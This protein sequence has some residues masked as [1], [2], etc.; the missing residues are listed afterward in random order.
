MAN[1]TT[2]TTVDD[3][4]N[5]NLVQPIIVLALSEQPGY[6][7][8]S[9]RQIDIRNQPTNT[10]KIP[11]EH[12]WWGSANDRGAGVATAFNQT[13]ATAISNTALS[14]DG[15]TSASATEYGV[16]TSLTDNVGE[17]SVQGIDLVQLFTTRMLS[18]LTL[19]LDDDYIGLFASL[20][21]T[22]GVSGSAATI[23]QIV[24]A[25]QGIRTRGAIADQVAYVLGN[26]TAGYIETALQSGTAAQF[27]LA[28]DRVIGYAPT[29][30]NGMGSNRMIAMFRGAPV[31]TT[32]LTDTA[33]AGADE[34]S[35]CVCPSSAVNDASGA[36][37]HGMV[38]KRLPRF[39]TQRQAKL[40]ATDLVMTSRFG[41]VEL[42]DGSG[43][44]IVTKST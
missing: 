40:R 22:V 15:V 29:P 30:D 23:A 33:N 16:A 28:A 42:Q 8:R 13:E 9:C 37:T 6:A 25:Q 19:A 17:D 43:T 34:V 31:Y 4:I 2:D 18:V 44:G 10:V 11:V 5:T 38:I 32:G 21:Q 27:M 7:L 1:E 41:L 20:S 36:T 39:E 26:I 14:T 3:L 35:A 12:S 24:A